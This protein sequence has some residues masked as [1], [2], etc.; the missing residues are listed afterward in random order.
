MGQTSKIRDRSGN[1][2]VMVN[3]IHVYLER[4]IRPI[5]VFGTE[6]CGG[7]GSRKSPGILD[8]NI[9]GHHG[10]GDD[11]VLLQR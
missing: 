8:A 1:F 10:P 6:N 7:F 2:K 11:K 5:A 3:D 4:I 9:Y